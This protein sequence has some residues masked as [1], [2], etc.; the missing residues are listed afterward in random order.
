MEVSEQ[1]H[2]DQASRTRGPDGRYVPSLETA[3]RD[4]EM[5]RM[6]GLGK[7]FREIGE[8]FGVGESTA[9]D[10]VQRCYDAT[11]REAGDQARL[12]ELDRLDRWQARTEETL[13]NEHIVISHGR[14]VRRRVHDEHG[15]WIQLT[16]DG[17]PL[18]NADGEPIY[19]EEEIPDDSA[20][21]QAVNTLLKI[22]QRRAALLGLDAPQKVEQ[23]GA[24]TYNLVGIDEDDM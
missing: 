23:S 11:R 15:Q 24:V 1:P 5:T 7:S 9:F 12:L 8:H 4:A 18:T 17:Q 16:H 10:G 13:A 19:L 2:G 3:Q 22:S 21:H 6:R 20:I 14:V